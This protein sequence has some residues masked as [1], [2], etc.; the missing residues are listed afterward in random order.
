MAPSRS[1]FLTATTSAGSPSS[2]AGRPT[3]SARASPPSD[4]SLCHFDMLNEFAVLFGRGNRSLEASEASHEMSDWQWFAASTP[5]GTRRGAPPPATTTRRFS[6]GSLRRP[7]RSRATRWRS[8]AAVP[9]LKRRSRTSPFCTLGIWHAAWPIARSANSQHR[10]QLEALG[11]A[12]WNVVEQKH[13]VRA[14]RQFESDNLSRLLRS[15][16]RS[17]GSLPGPDRRLELASVRRGSALDSG[18][19]A[20]DPSSRSLHRSPTASAESVRSACN[21]TGTTTDRR[22]ELPCI[23]SRRRRILCGTRSTLRDRR[24]LL[25]HTR[26]RD[27]VLVRLRT[28]DCQP[29]LPVLDPIG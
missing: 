14:G 3:R 9:P 10:A 22:Y 19:V 4:P 29:R 26:F 12:S 27:G 5:A 20:R 8:R 15:R 16:F 7:C 24:A 28:Q 6:S 18:H 1:T 2:T 11:A 21:R 25:D 23:V 13:Q 17:R